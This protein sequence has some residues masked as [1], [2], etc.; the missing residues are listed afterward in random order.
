MK[1][2][3]C[4][5]ID[6]KQLLEM[7]R[8]ETESKQQGAMRC[9]YT[10]QYDDAVKFVKSRYQGC[11]EVQILGIDAIASDIVLEGIVILKK[12]AQLSE[13]ELPKNLNAYCYGIWRNILSKLC[14]GNN[15]PALRLDDLTHK[16]PP[17]SPNTP[18]Q[19]FGFTQ[20]EN[21]EDEITSIKIDCL[22]ASYEALTS[23]QKVVITLF[24]FFGETISFAPLTLEELL[25]D[26]SLDTGEIIFQLD[27]VGEREERDSKQGKIPLKIIAEIMGITHN[28]AKNHNSKATIE[29]DKAYKNCMKN[30]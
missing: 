14:G 7:L 29:M 9:L 28:A 18:N 5:G 15:Q 21:E 26:Q 8:N 16:T 11:K 23:R 25:E 3:D 2:H 6:D 20:G 4:K 22:K 24:R 19:T 10:R 27:Q 12:L 17:G 30:Q 13:K 1:A